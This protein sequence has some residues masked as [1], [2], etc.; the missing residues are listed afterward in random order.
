VSFLGDTMNPLVMTPGAESVLEYKIASSQQR[1]GESIRPARNIT[2]NAQL[3][4]E[5][6]SL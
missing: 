3:N 2:R 5:N 1:K 4:P 6:Y